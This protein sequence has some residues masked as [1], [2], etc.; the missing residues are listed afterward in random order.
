VRAVNRTG[1][2]SI[3]H[4]LTMAMSVQF[5]WGHEDQRPASAGR[6]WLG[7]TGYL[8]LGVWLRL[9]LPFT[10]HEVFVLPL[11]ATE[12]P[13]F[14]EGFLGRFGGATLHHTAR[15]GLGLAPRRHTSAH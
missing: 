9:S 15:P 11:L 6:R 14:A 10:F 5:A 3:G 8:L 1:P 2:T 4:S 7:L 13:T 12:A